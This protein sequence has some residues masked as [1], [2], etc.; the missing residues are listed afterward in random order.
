MRPGPTLPPILQKLQAARPVWSFEA[1]LANVMTLNS[2]AAREGLKA[3]APV[4]R[5]RMI[6]APKSP[7]KF[8]FKRSDAFEQS[9]GEYPRIDLGPVVI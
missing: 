3:L 1:L 8:I 9:F 5:K 6:D 2:P 7:E 4:I